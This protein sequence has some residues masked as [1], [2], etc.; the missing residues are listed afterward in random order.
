MDHRLSTAGSEE[1]DECC[2]I[3]RCESTPD[4]PLFYPCACKGSIKYVHQD[5]LEQWLKHSRSTQ[6]E[7]CK[8]PFTFTPL[9]KEDVPSNL[10][11]SELALGIF[12]KALR[13]LRLVCRSFAALSL[14]IVIPLGTNVFWRMCFVRSFV[15]L[16]AEL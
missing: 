8:L 11:L 15:N 1:P 10:P 5:C 6:C 12:F 13:G 2:R 14:W 4:S 3:C 16:K 9:Y 7:V